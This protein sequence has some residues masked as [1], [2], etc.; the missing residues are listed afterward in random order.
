MIIKLIIY[1]TFLK[2]TLSE[3]LDK[4]FGSTGLTLPAYITFNKPITGLFDLYCNGYEG[5]RTWKQI[6]LK[7]DLNK[8]EITEL[9][10]LSNNICFFKKLSSH[11]DLFI[12]SYNNED[13]D[14][15]NITSGENN[16]TIAIPFIFSL[17]DFSYNNN[18]LFI[19]TKQ[20]Q[21]RGLEYEEIKKISTVLF[22]FN[23]N[24]L[25]FVKATV[26][27]KDEDEYPEKIF[28]L[29]DCFILLWVYEI[30]VHY[31][32]KIFDNTGNM[33][34]S[35]NY[36]L[37]LDEE[38]SIK[39]FK[40][41]KFSEKN[42]YNEFIACTLYETKS[43]CQIIRYVNSD[44]IFGKYFEI[45]SGLVKEG[46]EN[47]LNDIFIFPYEQY[48]MNKLLFI[49]INHIGNGF[50]KR[51]N[52]S[53][54]IA[55]YNNDVLEY[56]IN[57]NRYSYLSEKKLDRLSAIST[58]TVNEKG[59]NIVYFFDYIGRY[60]LTSTCDTKLIVL[61]PNKL[62]TF[63][64]DELVFKGLDDF[65]FAF[66][67]IP[68]NL[69]IF[70]YNKTV[71]VNEFFT[72]T[73]DF[74]YILNIAE[75]A[76]SVGVL[77]N[78]KT[79]MN[80]KDYICDVS[81][82]METEQIRVIYNYFKCW[83][84]NTLGR[85]NH[86]KS[87]N[88]NKTFY[89]GY[90]NYIE[91]YFTYSYYLPEDNELIF[92]FENTTLECKANNYN[93]TCKIPLVYIKINKTSY[94]YSKLSCENMVEIGWILI[95]D[96]IIIEAYDLM[97]YQQNYIDISRVYDASQKITQFNVDMLNYYY[98]FGCLAYCD[99][100]RITKKR[101]CPEILNDWEIV[102]NEEYLMDLEAFLML[103]NFIQAG[104]P[105]VKNLIKHLG[106]SIYYYNFVVLRSIK[107]KKIIFA[108]PGTTNILQL[109]IEI[110]C[111]NLVKIPN[112]NNQ[113]FQVSKMFYDTFDCIQKDFIKY[114][115][116]CENND[117]DYQT[118][119]IGHSLGGALATIASFYYVNQN[120]YKLEP[121]LI[122]FGQP[123]VG[124]ELFAKYLTNNIKQIY[125][126]ARANDPVTLIPLNKLYHLDKEKMYAL[127]D[128]YYTPTYPKG[129]EWLSYLDYMPDVHRIMLKLMTEILD[130]L[131]EAFNKK[132]SHLYLYTHIGGL[133]MIDDASRKI[134][135]CI[136]FYNA[137]T[138]HF[139]CKNN[140][141]FKVPFDIANHAYIKLG[142]N[143][144][145]N[146]QPFKYLTLMTFR[147]FNKNK[148]KKRVLD[149]NYCLEN[150]HI[151][152][153]LN[154]NDNNSPNIPTL[155]IIE[156]NKEFKFAKN[157]SEIWFKYEINKNYKN[158][159]ILK[160]DTN[161]LLFFGT[162]CFSQNLNSILNN[163][164]SNSC[165]NINTQY[166]FSLIIEINE[167]S[168]E[169][170]IYFQIKGKLSGYYE[171]LDLSKSKILNLYSSYYFPIIPDIEP[172][173]NIMLSVPDLQEN[174]YISFILYNNTDNTMLE[175]YE[176]GN[177]INFIDDE[178][179]NLIILKSNNK[180]EFKYYPYEN[181]LIINFIS[182]SYNNI[183]EK[184]FYLFDSHNFYIN[185]NLLNKNKNENISIF[186]DISGKIK[187]EGYFSG[188]EKFDNTLSEF[189]LDTK[190]KYI[191]IEN[192]L[193]NNFLNIKIYADLMYKYDFKIY[194]LKDI[195][196]IS[197]INY[198]YNLKK[199]QNI[200]FIIDYD[201]KQKYLAFESFI[202]LSINNP[203]NIFKI[204]ESN[205]LILKANNFYISKLLEVTGV[206]ISISENDIF[207]MKMIPEKISKKIFNNIQ[208]I[209]SNIKKQNNKLNI[210]YIYQQDYNSLFYQ[211]INDF[212]NNLQIYQLKNSN[213]N[214]EDI[215][216]NK[217][218][219]YIEV[220]NTTTMLEPYNTYIFIT[221]CQK[222]CMFMK[223]TSKELY[224]ENILD[225]SQIIYLYMDFT[226]NIMYDETITKIKIKKI[227]NFENIITV[228]CKNE[229]YTIDNIEKIINIGNCEGEFKI[230]GDNN[231]V[232]IYLPLSWS[233]DYTIINN[234]KSFSL[235]DCKEFF[236]VPNE[237]NYNSINILLSNKDYSND[238]EPNLI[239]YYIDYNIIPF[240]STNDKKYIYLEKTTTIIVP[241]Y[242]Q[243]NNINE[244][245]EKYFIYFSFNETIPNLEVTITFENIIN[246]NYKENSLILP[247][248][249]NVLQLGNQQNYY[250][251]ILNSKNLDNNNINIKYSIYRNYISNTDEE[252]ISLDSNSIYFNTTQ[253][254]DN[255]RIKIENEE[256]ILFSLSSSFFYDFSMIIYDKSINITQSGNY[257]NIKFNT[258]NYETKVEY[259]IIIIEN[260]TLTNLSD[261]LYHEILDNK[262]Y[263]YNNIISSR[264][265][266][267]ISIQINIDK[268][269]SYNQSY[270]NLIIGKEDFYD[271]YHY[272]YYEPKEFFVHEY[273]II[274]INTDNI[275][276]IDNSIII[277]IED[278]KGKK[279]EENSEK[280][281]SSNKIG[282]IVG[283]VVGVIAVSL[284]TFLGIWYYKKRNPGGI[285]LDS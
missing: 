3:F 94:I 260:N 269:L 245:T 171:L 142:Q 265:I 161:N 180:Y 90:K 153:L 65:S 150:Y 81:I 21:F 166:P 63:P 200:L 229:I 247:S 39:T 84:N 230:K 11:N 26:R 1:F 237:N 87:S 76:K 226:Y 82:E 251:N 4:R 248:G 6:L 62:N 128:E 80:Q 46:Y 34:I 277:N 168:E 15:I 48:G 37:K 268:Y 154:G 12:L 183:F 181:E 211:R 155:E 149:Y 116:L 102:F 61:A 112:V 235:K 157:I 129:F 239:K 270:I 176:N 78:L 89:K 72:D 148:S 206:F 38:E 119:F 75:P 17:E 133:Y 124:N 97:Y 263:I 33:L 205:G 216:N 40:I 47:W 236:F 178:S 108:F 10:Y 273:E 184:P 258:T 117:K 213:F 252:N 20:I 59:I 8:E 118:I 192:K 242:K 156:S 195:I 83:K 56:D 244:E 32:F 16:I 197:Q 280:N 169:K 172:T 122:T 146:C 71:G 253:N 109:L 190:E 249:I 187:I 140:D 105:S 238:D 91:I 173:K 212:D 272:I 246:I 228:F 93:V 43:I 77:Y 208:T 29:K 95:N 217:M 225:N 243:K 194:E 99:N 231:L 64:I 232:Y 92:Y 66:V 74:T 262:N 219:N 147:L 174:V 134:Y 86:I 35:K 14:K 281:G 283:V 162:I 145:S 186:F 88:V 60:Y 121:I 152:R 204:I 127:I 203:K 188:D 106:R 19:L 177:K 41:S 123:R 24:K 54:T 55:T 264:G 51:F 100:S 224:F 96:T 240:S 126:V 28:A 255:I 256:K 130:F 69:K 210:E 107:Y 45:F 70:K 282:I 104:N 191:N 167:V 42:E 241:N 233:N 44:L 199:G 9:T 58:V 160:I 144:I 259:T 25:T 143:M 141:F 13:E 111:S 257:I 22:F 68:E 267:P 49:C 163:D 139:I 189:I 2:I 30:K 223:Y 132:L 73:K 215:L 23:L 179:F 196:I 279:D 201:L 284:I 98:W 7:V 110:F 276:S 164:E 207:E 159:L 52:Y 113:D 185:Y 27:K 103:I 158:D 278:E 202:L 209:D 136:D 85:I 193:N 79:K 218:N 137:N 220:T 198:K 131:L 138:N 50:G 5:I 53:F 67:D 254:D 261:Y 114:L 170:I 275:D 285:K 31:A 36:S 18:I 274:D 182:V 250:I 271:S 57:I 165:Y 175:I 135:H 151:K 227:N 234:A 222:Q 266:E 115:S 101:C 125:R 221:K 214:L 120:K